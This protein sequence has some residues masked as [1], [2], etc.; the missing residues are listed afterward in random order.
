M[1]PITR[2]T[3]NN[4]AL[5]PPR[6]DLLHQ[7]S[8]QASWQFV[9]SDM[10]SEREVSEEP[11]SSHEGEEM[12]Y[13]EGEEDDYDDEAS[14]LGTPEDTEDIL[15]PLREAANRVGREVE[16]FAEVLD[17]YNPGR[18]KE[19][20]DFGT[21]MSLLDGYQNITMA[22]LRTLRIR[23]FREKRR[24]Q[25]A[26]RGGNIQEGR[27][28]NNSEEM[29]V[30]DSL[31]LA[32]GSAETTIE[33]LDRWEAEHKTW[34]LFKMILEAR[35]DQETPVEGRFSYPDQF[36]PEHEVWAG[37]LKE[38]PLAIERHTVLQWLKHSAE[39]AG[40]DVND[41]IADLQHKSDR[42][43]LGNGWLETK[44]AIK[45]QK[46]QQ[47]WPKP[48]DSES[49]VVSSVLVRKNTSEPLITQ[50]DPDAVTRQG[51][52]LE[53]AD[54]F[55]AQS[56]SRGCYELLRRGS[57]LDDIRDFCSERTE[58][59][60]AVGMSGF[61]GDHQKEEEDIENPI[62]C[63]LWRR[64]CFALARKGGGDI[65]ERAVYGILSGDVQ[66]VEPVCK[67]WDDFMF[68]HYN[69]LLH[70]HFDRYLQDIYIDDPSF[71]NSFSTFEAF[72]AVQFHGSP[73]GAARKLVENLKVDPRTANETLEPMNMLQG[74]LIADQF[75][76]FVYQQGL[77]LSKFANANGPSN[78]IPDTEERPENE[79]I[80]RYITMDDHD[81]LR[82]L[83]HML[84]VYKANGLKFGVHRQLMV[85]NIIVSYISFLRLA[86]KEELI[87]L[88]ASQL[89]GNRRYA[90]LSRNLIDVI[91]PEQR[92]TQIQLM[93]NLGLDV[94]EFVTFQAR[95][96]LRDYPDVD[97]E[98]DEDYPASHFRMLETD[99]RSDGTG[100]RIIADYFSPNPQQIDRIDMLLIRSL[101][102]FLLVDGLWS[103]TFKFGTVIYLRFFKYMRL[104]AARKLRNKVP[105]VEIALCKT[106][107]IL[108]QELDFHGL[109]ADGEDEDLTQVL[110][111]TADRKR[112]LRKH[113]VTEAKTF[114]ELETLITALDRLEDIGG[115][116]Q[117]LAE[118]GNDVVK[119]QLRNQLS[120]YLTPIVANVSPLL[121]GWLLSSKD[122]VPEHELL[123]EAYL[124][125]VVLGY[126]SVLQVGGL[127]LTR[128][129][130]M[131]CMEL[132]TIIADE[133]SDILALFIKQSRV[134][135]LA[136]A[137]ARAS[138][139]LLLADS[140]VGKKQSSS[141]GKRL[142]QKG[143]TSSIWKV[144]PE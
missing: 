12:G 134:E 5:I 128:D 6:S 66:S 104:N 127:S 79:E 133:D 141:K 14:P 24:M 52:K 47:T 71:T 82:V 58:L 35:Q 37:F 38:E 94:R 34:D 62:A 117:V 45:F 142:R 88:Y 9:G 126:I 105:A 26:A 15:H 132:S 107:K 119:K 69:A 77:A 55:F 112:L 65:Y 93:K 57:K 122:A 124:P 51:R 140:S 29:D 101:E 63:A 92:R 86:G 21:A 143:W 40:E 118:Q 87:P 18:V 28:L 136:E 109:E 78:L 61:P 49:S 81:S 2:S 68:A 99:P 3:R 98:V 85:D 56:I 80:T 137:F 144:T 97:D 95:N 131:E 53:T 67:T 1:A 73:D 8:R 33:D 111:G 11:T 139:T 106:R 74:V 100:R 121:K 48:L 96:L 31:E 125:E 110:D 16:R 22:T 30:E 7:N 27:D 70:T 76:D 39:E 36:S 84:L 90:T 50:L 4:G 17:Q 19:K 130:L 59:W 20:A 113:L 91:N 25:T 83:V 44:H 103:E 46:Q 129:Y 54:E 120:E 23:H 72:D 75:E 32:G 89:S 10:D 64:M 60:R 115:T 13:V 123:R 114:R 102:W 42:G 116:A 43:D 41:L 138:K 108:G 135:E